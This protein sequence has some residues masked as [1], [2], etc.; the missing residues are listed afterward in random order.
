M[1]FNEIERRREIERL[2]GEL[3]G[4][5]EESFW[6]ADQEYR[7]AHTHRNQ[8]F[9]AIEAKAKELISIIRPMI[10]NALG[11]HYTFYD[12]GFNNGINIDYSTGPYKS[13]PYLE[14]RVSC[15]YFA[16]ESKIWPRTAHAIEKTVRALKAAIFAYETANRAAQHKS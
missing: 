2:L 16:V 7:D 9:S 14:I 1:S 13:R 5:V 15:R 8:E 3:D 6:R 12:I 4:Y 10:R 11:K